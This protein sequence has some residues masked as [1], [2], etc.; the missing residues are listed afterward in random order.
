[1][2]RD[3]RHLKVRSVQHLRIPPY[4]VDGLEAIPAASQVSVGTRTYTEA[5]VRL[6]AERAAPSGDARRVIEYLSA[7]AERCEFRQD[8]HSERLI[9]AEDVHA[10]NDN[11]ALD[12]SARWRWSTTSHPKACWCC[13]PCA[14]AFGRRKP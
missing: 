8:K 11:V 7:A 13:S 6:L 9:S 2:F 4:T 5:T 12:T 14:G 3:R 10:M 1:M